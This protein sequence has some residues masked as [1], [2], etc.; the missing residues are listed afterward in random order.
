[1]P[2]IAEYKALEAQLTEQLK[3]LDTLKNDKELSER[4]SSRKN[5]GH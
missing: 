1:M 4:W 2:R 5:Y 3:Q